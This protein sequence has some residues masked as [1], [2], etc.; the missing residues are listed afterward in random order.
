MR[1]KFV[2]SVLNDLITKKELSQQHRILTVC[3]SDAEK[4]IFQSFGFKNVIISNLDTRLQGDEFTPY[5][6]AFQDAQNLTFKDNEFDY[7]FVSDGLHHCSSPHRALLEMYRVAKKGVIVFEARD[8]FLMR[9]ANRLNL[10][11][12]FELEAVVDNQF[13][14]GG[15][16]N[17][18]IPNYIYRWTE[19]EFEKTIQ[20]NNPIGAHQFFYFYSLNLPDDRVSMSNQKLL[21]FAIAA[22]KPFVWLFTF[23]FK[24]QCNSFSM[25][26]L[27]PNNNTDLWPWLEKDQGNLEFNRQ[28]AQTYFKQRDTK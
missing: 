17:T 9:M 19:R 24:G 14:H 22:A 10:C 18:G 11:P 21:R 12:E 5:D 25:V 1:V 6:W 23:F 26:V 16:N 27:K 7:A 8:S 15:V 20:T 13:I 3:A 4:E 28:Y 2:K